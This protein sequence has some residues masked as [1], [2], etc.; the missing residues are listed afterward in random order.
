MPESNL[1]G[2][3][4]KESKIDGTNVVSRSERRDLLEKSEYEWKLLRYHEADHAVVAHVLG[5]QPMYIDNDETGYDQRFFKS[6]GPEGSVIR[7]LEGKECARKRAVVSIAGP[8]AEAKIS[9]KSLAEMRAAYD[10][11]SD[12]GCVGDYW[13]IYDLLRGVTF[14]SL[15]EFSEEVYQQHLHLWEAQATAIL[16]KRSVW[17]AVG[18]V[19]DALEQ[20]LGNL[21]RNELLAAI[22]RGMRG[23]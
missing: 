23:G 22:E 16:N 21:G 12:D 11:I 8:A 10:V 4:A 3:E 20:N 14:H 6:L 9:G 7:T 5:L 1:V 13:R 2:D 17:D 19:A 18:S 15:F